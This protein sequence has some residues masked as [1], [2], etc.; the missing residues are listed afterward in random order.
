MKSFKAWKVYKQWDTI[1]D[2]SVGGFV[3]RA[4]SVPFKDDLILRATKKASEQNRL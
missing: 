2:T 4:L 3:T 1:N